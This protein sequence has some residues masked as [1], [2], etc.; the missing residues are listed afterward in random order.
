MASARVSGTGRGITFCVRVTNQSEADT[1]LEFSSARR[2]RV[3]IT[4]ADNRAIAVVPAGVYA[5]AFTTDTVAAGESRTYDAAWTAPASGAY[6][7]VIQLLT[8]P[9]V[10]FAKIPFAVP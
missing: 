1:T 2:L 10:T 3:S 4:D 7:A 9:T 6:A 8:H 5:Q